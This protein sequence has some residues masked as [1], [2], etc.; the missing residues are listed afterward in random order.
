[1]RIFIV[2]LVALFCLG[3]LVACNT[4]NVGNEGTTAATN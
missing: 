4:K 2:C 1:M 3:S